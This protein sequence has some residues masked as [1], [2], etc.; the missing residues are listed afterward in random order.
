MSEATELDILPPV[1][2]EGTC[3]PTGPNQ[4]QLLANIILLGAKLVVPQ[5]INGFVRSQ[6]E[7]SVEDR[8]KLWFK[9]D[10]NNDIT[11]WY[12]YSEQYS[13]WLWPVG[14]I[15]STVERRV[16]L[17]SNVSEVW[18]YDGGSGDN[19]ATTFPTAIS[20][21]MWQEDTAFA[22]KFP[23]GAGILPSGTVLS[24]SGT[25]G[26]EKVTLT[27]AE[28]PEAVSIPVQTIPAGG[29]PGEQFLQHD[30]NQ[31]EDVGVNRNEADNT[32][33]GGQA[34][35]N[36]PPYIVVVFAKRTI[37]QYYTP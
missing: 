11:G 20:G 36:I 31:E 24:P 22:A 19:P 26:E 25:G 21:A 17:V 9:T 35:N 2:P 12:F 16:L 8:G 14:Q 23:I 32:E 34:H 7:P 18:L 37:R 30:E 15:Y 10:P 1:I 6:A 27:L 29:N 5:G 3:I 28:I 33:G 13:Q 4:L